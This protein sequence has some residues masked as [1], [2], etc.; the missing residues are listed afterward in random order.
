LKRISLGET[1]VRSARLALTPAVKLLSATEHFGVEEPNNDILEGVLWVSPGQRSAITGFVNFL[2]QT[3]DLGLVLPE[4]GELVVER[5]KETKMQ[6]RARIIR[7]LRCPV[8]ND[9]YSCDL[10]ALSLA[11]FH[12]VAPP[13]SVRVEHK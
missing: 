9:G 1:T 2:N 3:Y 6:L 5:P 13:R 8:D 12:Q 7:M 4:K 11:Y 10:L